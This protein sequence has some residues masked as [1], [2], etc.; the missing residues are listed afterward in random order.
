MTVTTSK[1]G[2]GEKLNLFFL[3]WPIFLEVFLF[4]LMGIADTFMLSALSDDA[5]SGVGA[6][7]QYLH[8]AIL[9]LEVIGNG[10]A[11]VVSQ[12]LGSK[13][14]ME[15]SKISALAVTLNLGVGLI[16]SAGFLLFSK[17]MMMTMNL[18]GDVLTYAQNYLSI[19]GGAIFLQAII[20]SLAAIIRVHGFT[21]QAMLI[22][23]GMNIFHI[24]G[25]YVL[26]FGKFG[27]PEMGV[28][29]AAISSS[30][31]R[32]IA[33][34]VFFWLLY[35]VMEY[36]V[37]LNYYITL[38]KEYIGKILKIGI[39]SAFEQVMYQACQ[40]VFLYYAT[41]LGAESL[42]ARQYATNISMFT[43]LFAIAIGM[44]TAIIVG[45]LVGGNEKDE[46]YVR[47]WKSVKWA[48][49][50][51]LCMV[52]LVITFR[53]QLMGLFTDNP[54][55]IALGATVLLLSILL[56]TGRTMNIVI[57]NS[58]RAA[59]DAKYPVLIGAFSMVLMS[60][61]LGYFFVFYLHMGLP[62]IWLA[63]AIDEWTRAIIMFFRWKS[64]AWENYALVKPETSEESAPV[65]A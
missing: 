64:R 1:K 16:I 23:L 3:T 31:S 19:V 13:R 42:A 11:I 53:T 45:H 56:E 36:R 28:Q 33:L 37:K 40:I 44:G 32:L 4:M 9:V 50:V 54:H 22:S 10:A 49:G 26:I 2:Q 58:L 43:Y 15:A 20:N 29:G 47:V 21:K 57:I 46:A 38:S 5:V 6:A 62:G 51:T 52:I 17:N 8:I 18:Q 27:F 55:V 60:L 14:Y 63:I 34:I 61:P 25:N 65:Q 24:A 48:I 12:Y 39:P 59:G 41:Y 30:F 7:N 35:R